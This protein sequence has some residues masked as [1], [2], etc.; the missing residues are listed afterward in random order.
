M[1]AET[2]ECST[3]RNEVGEEEGDGRTYW[4][5]L[6]LLE[7][8]GVQ[9]A[10]LGPHEPTRTSEDSVRVRVSLGWH[11]CSLARGAKAMLLVNSR[12]GSFALMV[13]SAARRLDWKLLRRVLPQGKKW[14]MASEDQ[15]MRVTGCLPGAVPPFGSVFQNSSGEDDDDSGVVVTYMD[16]SLREQGEIIN[17]NAGLRTRSVEITLE[18]YVRI[19]KPLECS[20]T[21]AQDVSQ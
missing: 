12:S 4:R 10:H 1:A 13:M 16:K 11:D 15:V 14:G 3:G 2:A 20:I 6:A 5:V 9:Y 8:H 7:K 17:F 18:D 19:E 21:T